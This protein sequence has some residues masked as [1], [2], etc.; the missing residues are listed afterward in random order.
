MSEMDTVAGHYSHGGLLA[1]IEAGVRALGKTPE[2]VTVDDL[3]PV[4]EFHI[5]GR[6]ASEAFLGQLRFEPTDQVLDIGC[7]LG[8]TAR[9]VAD[10]FGC[11]VTGIDL[12]GD[13]IE[14]GQALCGW[15]GLNGQVRLD[16]GSALA[17]PYGVDSFD[18]AFMM[19]VGMN[20]ADKKLLFSEVYRVLKPG[21]M[22]G[23]YDVMRG[24]LDG[25]VYPVPWT[26]TAEAN[27][28]APSADYETALAA[29]GFRI[30]ANRN[31]RQF[32]IE[33][34]ASLRAANA[35]ANGPPPLGL[36]ILMGK[37]AAQKVGN[38]VANIQEGRV[39]PVEMIAQKPELDP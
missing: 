1:A 6:Q 18:R 21:G 31:R 4:D 35:A 15:L 14:T 32:A 11:Q 16:Q 30:A 9:F 27:W 37:S 22:F 39:A 38:L 3:G 25:F 23:L 36:H 2:T 28:V 34:F 20:I 13:Y 33:F 26:S 29:A 8:G 10:R 12:T 17:M 5:G 24:T 7:G 19:H